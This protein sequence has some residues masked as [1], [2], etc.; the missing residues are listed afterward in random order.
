LRVLRSEKISTSTKAT[1]SPATIT[2]TCPLHYPQG[3][4]RE[5]PYKASSQG[6]AAARSTPSNRGANRRFDAYI[7]TTAPLIASG[8]PL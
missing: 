7:V 2:I 1:I 8:A 3:K 5:W 4:R 6:L